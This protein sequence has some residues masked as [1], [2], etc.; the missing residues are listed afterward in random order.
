[1]VQLLRHCTE[2]VL[3]SITV[4]FIL[5]A[6]TASA[7]LASWAGRPLTLIIL[8]LLFIPAIVAYFLSPRLRLLAA[9][10]FFFLIGL[11]HTHQAL[12]PVSDPHHIARSITEKTK[13]TV[14]GRILTMVEYDGEKSRFE[15]DTEEILLHGSTAPP[16]CNR[17][18]AKSS[19]LC[20]ATS[21]RSMFRG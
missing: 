12:Q 2:N 10:P 13:A 5:G 17:F 1:M 19:S 9:L 18:G 4:C 20:W 16:R 21:L 11:L 6:S 3:I 8:P 15:L 14:V 7:F